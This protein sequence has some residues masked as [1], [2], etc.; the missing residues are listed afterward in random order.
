MRHSA[1]TPTYR[2]LKDRTKFLKENP[3][4]AKA[5][6]FSPGTVGNFTKEAEALKRAGYATGAKYVTDL[7]K[8]R[9]GPTMRRAVAAAQ[10]EGCA[11]QLPVIELL[12]KDGA[13]VA[14][15]DTLISVTLGERSYEAMSDSFGAILVRVAPSATGNLVLKVFNKDPKEWVTLDPVVLPDPFRPLTITLV[16]PT[17]RVP[18]S[19]R[20]HEKRPVA[21]APDVAQA[22]P[23][24]AA[25]PHA[26]ASRPATVKAE[27]PQALT[28]NAAAGAN[29]HTIAKGETLCLIASRYRLRYKTIA[30]LN[31]I[32][33]PHVI[34]PGQVLRLPTVD[35]QGS[36]K[37]PPQPSTS[38][39][40]TVP[41]TANPANSK[42]LRF[43]PAKPQVSV[44]T[45][46][47]PVPPHSAVAPAP[48]NPPSGYALSGAGEIEDST[49]ALHVA[50]FRDEADKPAT[51]VMASLKTPWMQ[52]AEGEFKAGVARVRG[53]A[54][55][56]HIVAYLETTNLSKSMAA[57]D[58][59]AWCA[60]F[61]NWC[62]VKAGYKGTNNAMAASF[63][64]WGRSTRGN[65]AALGAVALIRYKGGQHHVTFVAGMD[66][67]GKKL[68][69]LGGNQGRF[70]AVTHSQVDT[71]LVLCY[72]YPSDYPD[73]DEDYVLHEIDL[74]GAPLTAASTR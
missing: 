3:R 53:R 41:T 49:T 38:H 69:S 6:L 61:C 46:P 35:K 54:A 68:F 50:Y 18:T 19:T 42:E 31:G 25:A 13:K 9:K 72:R 16:A 23:A 66:K 40:S 1:S 65:K 22:A 67:S 5:G 45:P 70:H 47:H 73:Y 58:E 32:C 34:R 71:D 11:V 37:G 2:S 64:K 74:D 51:V 48:V 60:A 10:K 28:L 57:M 29:T 26:G 4:Y 30:D 55:N 15:A 21:N 24:L 56:P 63:Q 62:L 7:E 33:S 43:P 52:A 44:Y 17:I 39:A 59:T 8:I 14:L 27:A 12:L 20:V 36:A